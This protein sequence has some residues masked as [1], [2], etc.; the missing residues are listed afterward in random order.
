M[1]DEVTDAGQYVQQVAES[2]ING[3]TSLDTEITA[4]LNSWR[5]TSADTFSEGWT[6]T[7]VGADSVLDALS[8]MAELLGVTT[9]T[10]EDQDVSNAAATSAA[11]SPVHR[12]NL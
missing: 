1:P 11:V 9:K 10:L 7:K 8:I 6:E 4:L 12:L 3:L 2:L 5:G